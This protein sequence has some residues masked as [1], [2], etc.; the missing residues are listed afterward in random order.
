MKNFIKTICLVCLLTFSMG[1]LGLST[2]AKA[3]EINSKNTNVPVTSI[4]QKEV[5]KMLE[6]ISPYITYDKN[7]KP[8]LTTE[9]LSKLN[10]TKTELKELK[11]GMKLGENV[12]V[13]VVNPST[14]K[15]GNTLG[16]NLDSPKKATVSYNTSYL[17]VTFSA[18]EVKALL[19]V[20]LIAGLALTI[21]GAI[22]GTSTVWLI[23]SWLVY[24]GVFLGI[25]GACLGTFASLVTLWWN[26][27]TV[28][29]NI[30]IPTIG[31]RSGNCS[32]TGKNAVGM[33]STQT[34]YASY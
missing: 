34:A 30:P 32:W 21:A 1:A 2:I 33:N 9:D 31:N 19:T 8:M 20:A 17:T 14:T 23:G 7:N 12:K 25:V 26:P 4:D 3:S 28:T 27:S 15:T 10:I 5:S 16:A 18:T 11:E 29:I 13:D 6:K 24:K 22:Y